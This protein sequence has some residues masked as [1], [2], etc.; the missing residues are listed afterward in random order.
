MRACGCTGVHVSAQ[1][2]IEEIHLQV[3]LIWQL[4]IKYEQFPAKLLGLF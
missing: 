2:N 3:D 1:I 4:L